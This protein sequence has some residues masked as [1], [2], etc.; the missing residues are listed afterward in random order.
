MQKRA[1]MGR[2]KEKMG[3]MTEIL[4]LHGWTTSI[5][6]WGPLVEG[7][8]EKNIRLKIPSIPGLTKKISKS[9][10]LED[11]IDWL[12]KQIKTKKV[13]LLGHSNG[14]RIAIAFSATYPQSVKQLI[15]ID[16]AGIYHNE[17]PIKIKRF[18]F[19]SAAKLGKKITLPENLRNLLYKLA[20]EE[21][22]KNAD[23]LQR[24]IMTN[25][26][27]QDLTPIL[28]KI[29]IPT[30]LLWG[31]KDKTTPL[32]DGKLMHKLIKGSKLEIIK[33]ARHSPHYTNSKEVAEKINEYL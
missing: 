1:G 22:Y 31:E 19:K 24:Q 13:V 5:E 6:K 21:D 30:L 20:K 28:S 16:S 10:T 18:L 29:K 14:G 26:I 27:S 12:K 4:A 23:P 8:L 17:F 25:L 7:L 9:W 32:S 11:Y 15:L 3:A 33:G 2:K